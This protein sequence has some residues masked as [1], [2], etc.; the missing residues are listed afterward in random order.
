MPLNDGQLSQ[1]DFLKLIS[2]LESSGGK[3]LNHPAIQ[4]GLQAGT[5]AAGQYGLMPN[6]IQELVNRQRLSGQATPAMRDIASE[7]PEQMKA[8]VESNP[9]ME[10]QLAGQ[11]ATKVLGN[12]QDP[13]M[14]A[15]AWHSGHNLQP[16]QIQQRDYM[17]DPYVQKFLKL[18]EMLGKPNE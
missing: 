15:Y 11:L 13:A 18:K 6:T 1:E 12:T 3:N 5:T 14:A 17:N 10:N 9:D 16:Q 2:Q 7:P 8:D 4:N